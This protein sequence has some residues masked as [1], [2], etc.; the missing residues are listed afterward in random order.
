MTLSIEAADEYIDVN[1][2]D[3]EDWTDCDEARKQRIINVASRTLTSTYPKY[4]IPDA[5]VYE[6]ATVLATAFNDTLRQAQ[7]GVSSFSLTDVGSFTFRDKPKELAGLIPPISR[8]L[9]GAENDVKL[10]S[11]GAGWSVL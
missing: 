3:I 8:E 6:F 5:A 4:T 2:I 11:R 1:V 9:I 7:N 10:G